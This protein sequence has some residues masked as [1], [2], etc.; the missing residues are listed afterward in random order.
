MA[1]AGAAC[2]AR[3]QLGS[4]SREAIDS[5]PAAHACGVSHVRSAAVRSPAGGISGGICAPDSVTVVEGEAKET[6]LQF[7]TSPS[8]SGQNSSLRDINPGP[9]K[10]ALCL[11]RHWRNYYEIPSMIREK[12][13][14]GKPRSGRRVYAS[15]GE[16]GGWKNCCHGRFPWNSSFPWPLSLAAQRRG[17]EAVSAPC[18][19]PFHCRDTVA[20]SVL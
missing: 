18:L 4:A 14:S 5:Q 2:L 17:P 10:L 3:S 1:G 13:V 11:P 9:R 20:Y 8:S 6:R 15:D 16:A 12:D 7:N 19:P